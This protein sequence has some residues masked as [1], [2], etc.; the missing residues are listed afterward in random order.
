MCKWWTRLHWC[1]VL[2]L[3]LGQVLVRIRIVGDDNIDSFNEL[4]LTDIQGALDTS[5][6]AYSLRYVDNIL[7]IGTV[8]NYAA[9]PIEVKPT[10]TTVYGD[11]GLHLKIRMK[12]HGM[13]NQLIV[14]I[15]RY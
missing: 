1:D 11:D 14:C 15:N 5:A 6:T 9:A 13:Y 12:N 10:S 7:G 8:I 4:I 2:T 3:E